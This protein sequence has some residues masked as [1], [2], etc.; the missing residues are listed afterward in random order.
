MPEGDTVHRTARRL[1]QALVGEVLTR[2]DFRVPQAATSDLAG[3][4]VVASLARGKHL[5]L[6]IGAG[7]TLHTHLAMEGAWHLHRPGSR[8]RRPAHEARV[9]LETDRWQAVGFALGVVELLPRDGEEAAVAHLG[10]DLLGPD[11]DADVALARLQAAPDVTVVTALLDQQ[12]LAGIGN[13]YAC[14]TLFL[15]GIHPH[16]PVGD[17]PGLPRLVQR[18]RTLLATNL[19]RDVRTTTGSLAR[20]RRTWVHGRAGRPCRRCGSRIE[21]E[22]FGRSGRQRATYWCPHCQPAR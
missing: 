3:A 16:T 8:W 9:V 13:I 10:P 12:N 21:L 6:R 2:T 22:M 15:G 17:V 4:E 11:W 18:A 7:H 1:E 5:L 19:D 14:E 20:G